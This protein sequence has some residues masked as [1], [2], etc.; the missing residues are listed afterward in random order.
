MKLIKDLGT[1]P[2]GKNKIFMRR[3]GLYEC[4]SCKQ[5]FETSFNS[6]R[7]GV[8]TGCRSCGSTKHGYKK[9]RLYKTWNNIIQRCNNKKNTRYSDYGGRGIK[10]CD[11]WLDIKNFIEDMYPTFIEGLEIDRILVN[12][13]YEKSNCRWATRNV[14]ARNTRLLR[15]DNSS[16]YRGVT[17]HSVEKKFRAQI[18]INGDTKRCA[19]CSY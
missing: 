11:R 18:G 15:A 1:R 16:G 9:H 2:T 3:F 10:V 14:Q 6:V 19:L 4:P 13:G 7:Q 12:V 5:E 8:S 17:F